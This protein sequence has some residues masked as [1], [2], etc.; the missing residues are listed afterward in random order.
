MRPH[1]SSY[2]PM[3]MLVAVGVKARAGSACC[4]GL[5]CLIMVLSPSIVVFNSSNRLPATKLAAYASVW[6]DRH[7]ILLFHG[8]VLLLACASGI[9]YDF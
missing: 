5:A 1:S 3:S 7:T 8:Q 4:A 6:H 2:D 9:A